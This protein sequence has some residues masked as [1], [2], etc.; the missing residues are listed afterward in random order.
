MRAAEGTRHRLYKNEL[1]ACVATFSPDYSQFFLIEPR[2]E[3]FRSFSVVPPSEAFASLFSKMYPTI[4]KKNRSNTLSSVAA[5]GLMNNKG[6][7]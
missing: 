3:Y 1:R 4:G 7:Y 2:I 6:E 5:A